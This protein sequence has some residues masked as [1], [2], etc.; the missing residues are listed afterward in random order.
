MESNHLWYQQDREG[1]RRL[2][3]LNGRGLAG[4]LKESESDTFSGGARRGMSPMDL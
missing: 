3:V 2:S 1:E 4:Q